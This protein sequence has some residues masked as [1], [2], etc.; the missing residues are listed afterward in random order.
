M[1]HFTTA[2]F[3]KTNDMSEVEK[4]LAPYDE[5]L[6]VKPYKDEYGEES[7]YNPKSKWD[8]Y[9]IGGRW[10]GLLKL[11]DGKSGKKGEPAYGC[12]PAEADEYDSC[13][14]SDLNFEAMKQ[15]RY[16]QMESFEN[17]WEKKFYKPEY[18]NR[19][20]PSEYIYI[21]TKT[22]FGT[23]SVITPDGNWHSCGEMGLFGCSSETPEEKQTFIDSYYEM[24]IKPAI[25]NGWYITIVDC[26]I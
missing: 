7:T 15:A 21:K 18:F 13:L 23:H 9:E 14:T 11:K 17:C 10:S 8:W 2:V 26:H 3:T 25:E 4:L 12:T 1:S 19:M 5:N 6:E 24:F 22:T 20:Y 16:T